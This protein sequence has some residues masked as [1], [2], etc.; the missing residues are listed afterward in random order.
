MTEEEQEY[1]HT[2]GKRIGRLERA[3]SLQ[4]A[5]VERLEKA[6]QPRSPQVVEIIQGRHDESS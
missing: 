3:L 1:I 6:A 2:L 5:I 4:A